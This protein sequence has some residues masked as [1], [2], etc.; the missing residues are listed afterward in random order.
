MPT[1]LGLAGLKPIELSR[2]PRLQ[3]VKSL[4][5]DML[6]VKVISKR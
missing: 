3:G 1:K 5:V 2:I 6:W 4:K